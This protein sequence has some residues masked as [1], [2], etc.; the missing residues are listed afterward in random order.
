MSKYFSVTKCV[1]ITRWPGSLSAAYILVVSELHTNSQLLIYS[2][3][4]D[5]S[6]PNH[7]FLPKHKFGHKFVQKSLCVHADAY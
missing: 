1:K 6:L 7:H 4:K 5:I 2:L 3:I